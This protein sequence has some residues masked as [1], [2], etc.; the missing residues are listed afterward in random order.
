MK[1]DG[2]ASDDQAASLLSGE[3]IHLSPLEARSAG[4]AIR[5]Q[6]ARSALLIG[7]RRRIDRTRSPFSSDRMRLGSPSSCR[8]GTVGCSPP[9]SVPPRLG[10]RDGLRLH[11][12]AHHRFDH[13]DLR[14]RPP[15][16]LRNVRGARPRSG[17]RC[18]RFRRNPPG[19]LGMGCEATGGKRRGGGQ[20]GRPLP[21]RHPRGRARSGAVVSGAAIRALADLTA[22]ALWYRRIDTA[23]IAAD[24]HSGRLLRDSSGRP[25]AS[26]RECP[27]PPRREGQR[28]PEVRRRPPADHTRASNERRVPSRSGD[29]RGLRAQS[30]V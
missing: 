4:R 23:D 20:G 1:L 30:S 27:R 5:R 15:I 25:A 9:R 11:P 7:Y 3:A 10:G 28:A 16:E 8:S 24:R 18:Q 22:L 21:K 26:R 14:R 12:H 13:P 19:T 2:P 6:V 17:L 29:V